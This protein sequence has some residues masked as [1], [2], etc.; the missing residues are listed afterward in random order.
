MEY[1]QQTQ[2]YLL[3]VKNKKLS[4]MN[5]SFGCLSLSAALSEVTGHMVDFDSTDLYYTQNDEDIVQ[6]AL[7]GKYTFDELVEETKK[8]F[9]SQKEINYDELDVVT[10]EQLKKLITLAKLADIG[11]QALQ[12]EGTPLSQ[13][14]YS[15]ARVI[16]PIPDDNAEQYIDEF[17]KS[18]D[19]FVWDDE[20]NKRYNING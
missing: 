6:G 8:Y 17:L 12:E 18:L 2:D 16:D 14:D 11:A 13:L 5:Q 4:M 19:V 7:N 9:A 1:S 10:K 3:S 20:N 15:D